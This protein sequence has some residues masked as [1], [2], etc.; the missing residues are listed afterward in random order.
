MKK[1]TYYDYKHKV[2]TGLEYARQQF[3]G[4]NEDD[5]ADIYPHEMYKGRFIYAIRRTSVKV[6]E[7]GDIPYVE[8]K[9]VDLDSH[10][11]CCLCKKKQFFGKIMTAQEYLKSVF[12]D[13][14]VKKYIVNRIFYCD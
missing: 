2:C 4:E 7:N 14:E 8:Y 1:Y 5:L 6:S 11:E 13:R 9:I 12:K 3:I 10:N